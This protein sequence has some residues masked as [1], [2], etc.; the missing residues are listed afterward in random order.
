MS[1]GRFC[2]GF[3]LHVSS[4]RRQSSILK[5]S[6]NDKAELEA[7]EQQALEQ[8]RQPDPAEQVSY[9]AKL[10]EWA[11]SDDPILKAE[12]LRLLRQLE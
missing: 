9:L 7:Q 3:K 11:A 12:G 2:P 8:K 4:D 1:V 5:A 10:Q 6:A